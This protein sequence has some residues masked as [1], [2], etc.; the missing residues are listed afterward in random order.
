MKFGRVSLCSSA[1]YRVLVLVKWKVWRQKC[2]VG[3]RFSSPLL[4]FTQCYVICCWKEIIEIGDWGGSEALNLYGWGV[5]PDESRLCEWRSR[6]ALLVNTGPSPVD[7]GQG[8]KIKDKKSKV[9]TEECLRAPVDPDVGAHFVVLFT[10]QHRRSSRKSSCVSRSGDVRVEERATSLAT[11]HGLV[12]KQIRP[13][14]VQK[15]EILTFEPTSSHLFAD[16]QVTCLCCRFFALALEAKFRWQSHW[17]MR[18]HASDWPAFVYLQAA[19]LKWYNL[20]PC[21]AKH[22]SQFFGAAASYNT[23]VQYLLLDVNWLLQRGKT[24]SSCITLWKTEWKES[25]TLEGLNLPYS[26]KCVIPEGRHT[27]SCSLIPQMHCVQMYH[28]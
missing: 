18:L 25:F 27:R 11:D 26:F 12:K 28:L 24:A 15:V 6:A 14:V 5:A 1:E 4:L 2:S 16:N 9:W 17:V 23:D 13:Y 19:V 3:D 21:H 10:L 22:Q 8:V 20:Q 7:R